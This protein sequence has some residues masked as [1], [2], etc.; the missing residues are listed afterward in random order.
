MALGTRMAAAMEPSPRLP[1]SRL[2]H[3]PN[4]GPSGDD[5]WKSWADQRDHRASAPIKHRTA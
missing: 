4:T 1:L 2:K 5:Q 3:P